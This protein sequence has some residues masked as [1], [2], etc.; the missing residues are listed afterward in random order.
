RKHAKSIHDLTEECENLEKKALGLQEG[1]KNGTSYNEVL[2]ILKE[3][4]EIN[5]KIIEIGAR[6]LLEEKVYH[7]FLNKVKEI[8]EASEDRFFDKAL[9]SEI[10][11]AVVNEHIPKIEEITNP[12]LRRL[13]SIV[14]QLRIEKIN[15]IEKKADPQHLLAR[16][17]AK[18]RF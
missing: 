5:Q 10:Q 14:H 1:V 16:K 9:I 4:N 3:L 11:K 2:P 8:R 18:A 7:Q 6:N 12:E 17:E 15:Q 13:F